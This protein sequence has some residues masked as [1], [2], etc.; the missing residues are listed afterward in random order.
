MVAMVGDLPGEIRGPEEGM[1][2][3]RGEKVKERGE[4]ATAGT[5]ESDNVVDDLMI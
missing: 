4:R 5:H 1:H 2:H 3:L